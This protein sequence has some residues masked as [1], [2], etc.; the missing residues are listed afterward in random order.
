MEKALCLLIFKFLKK[1]A[2]FSNDYFFLK[3]EPI[4]FI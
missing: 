2:K 1:F 4:P 3:F